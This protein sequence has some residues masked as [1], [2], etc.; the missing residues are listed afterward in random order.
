MPVE[1]SER[2][3]PLQLQ[4]SDLFD[5]QTGDRTADD[6]LLDLLGALEDVVGVQ[7]PFAESRSLL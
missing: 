1:T 3:K 4:G 7:N 5:P 2:P 6:Q